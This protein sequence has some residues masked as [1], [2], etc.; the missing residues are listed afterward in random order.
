MQLTGAQI[1]MECLKE[2]GVDTVFGYPGGSVIFIYDELYRRTDIRHIL[3]A[4][5]QAAAHAADGYARAT[6]KP[7]VCLATSGPG[8]TNL[9]T[10]IATA[11]MDSV[12]LVAITGNVAT[13]L[14]GKDSFQEVDIRGI[15]MP[16]TK[17]NYIVRNIEDLADTLRKAFYIAQEGRPGPVL[18]DIPKD[19]TTA[20]CEYS[21]KKPQSVSRVSPENDADIEEAVKLIKASKRPM[22]YSGGGVI[23]DDAADEL[24]TLAEKLACPVALSLMGIGGFPADHPQYT[25]MIGMHG[26]KASNQA[27]ADCDLLIA[28]GARFS[29]RVIGKVEGFAPKAQILHVDIDPAEVNKNV[30]TYHAIV[31]SVKPILQAI[32]SK[33]DQRQPGE[34][35]EAVMENKRKFPIGYLKD[36]KLRPQHILERLSA[37]VPDDAVVVTEVGQNQMWA[38]Q[39]YQP[40][41]PRT[42][43]TSGGLGTMGFG[44]GAAMGAKAAFPD[45]MVFNVAGD[46]CFHMNCQ[47]LATAVRE[48]LPVKILLLNNSVLGMVRQWQTLFC[49]KRYSETTLEHQ[50]DIIKLAEAFGATAFD[51]TAP[52]QIDQV[53]KQA[54]ETE[55]TVVVNCIIDPDEMVLPMVPPGSI[56]EALIIE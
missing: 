30:D 53:L 55:G 13:P 10:G 25:G 47:E 21:Y 24:E 17:H 51:I 50:T 2:Q 16:I 3:T 8:A 33:L 1:I 37:L 52:N 46:G 9:V 27:S 20:M 11:Y 15:T 26:T 42:F 40:N 56:I 6:G 4:H 12:P 19:L 31:G 34:W 28:I 5:E 22:I 43:I 14:L 7:G 49:E 23:A 38:A 36:G 41:G 44:L 54:M 29:D 18:V 32:I 35:L 48:K 45:R 39:F